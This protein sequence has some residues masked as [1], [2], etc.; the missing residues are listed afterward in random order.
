MA[1]PAMVVANHAGFWFSMPF[2][3]ASAWT[4]SSANAP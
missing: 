1:S 4:A 2:S 3:Y